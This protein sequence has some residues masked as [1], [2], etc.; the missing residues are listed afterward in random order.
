MQQLTAVW[1]PPPYLANTLH[2]DA[3]SNLK[4]CLDN[5]VNPTL[6]EEIL[7]DAM[8]ALRQGNIRRAVIEA[9][10]CAE[11]ATRDAFSFDYLDE[12]GEH[13]ASVID[14]LGRVAR[15]VSGFNFESFDPVAFDHVRLLFAT[16]NKGAHE[17][18]PYYKE[19]DGRMQTVT[20]Q[21]AAEWIR[22][23]EVLLFWLGHSN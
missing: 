2:P 10:V 8:G 12:R 20:R 3:D 13:Q 15:A 6:V 19:T 5:M 16:R 22:S 7:L 18:K 11:V 14:L 21:K 4:Y 9:A 1:D 17:G 23:V